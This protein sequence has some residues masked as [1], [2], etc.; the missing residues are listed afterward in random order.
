[1]KLRLSPEVHKITHHREKKHQ[2]LGSVY[3]Y[4]TQELFVMCRSQSLGVELSDMCLHTPCTKH[5]LC[6]HRYST[7]N[8]AWGIGGK[9]P[10]MHCISW[11]IMCVNITT[12]WSLSMEGDT[13]SAS[14]EGWELSPELSFTCISRWVR[15]ISGAVQV[16][17]RN[18]NEL[19][20][21]WFLI[22]T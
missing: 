13:G 9:L 19:K 5:G 15:A 22:C 4:M 7:E 21:T 12:I 16:N 14:A 20:I 2:M 17:H 18:I 11:L 8:D 10:S 3:S 6:A 1:M